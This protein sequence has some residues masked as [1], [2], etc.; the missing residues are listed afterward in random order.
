MRKPKLRGKLGLG[1]FFFDALEKLLGLETKDSTG[2]QSLSQKGNVGF[3]RFHSR[4]LLGSR[5]RT[6]CETG[7]PETAL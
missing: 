3:V 4:S 1:N 6:R 5:Q 7:R 2:E